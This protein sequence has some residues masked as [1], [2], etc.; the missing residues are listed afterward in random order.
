M[1]RYVKGKPVTEWIKGKSERNEALDLMV[2]C[3]AMAH[4]LGLDRY[5]ERDW[6]RVAQAL[7]QAELFAEKVPTVS[8]EVSRPVIV[9]EPAMESPDPEPDPVPTPAAPPQPVA[10]PPQRRSSS[11]GYLKRR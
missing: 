2:Y 3:L 6:D 11:S 5:K 7:A 8:S 10:R 4:Y 1:T 9:S